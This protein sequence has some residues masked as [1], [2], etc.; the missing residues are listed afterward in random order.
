MRVEQPPHGITT[1]VGQ[2]WRTYECDCG[3]KLSSHDDHV[4]HLRDLAGKADRLTR[5]V[6]NMID[7]YEERAEVYE[8]KALKWW[9]L[10]TQR[11]DEY[12]RLAEVERGRADELRKF[13][14][15]MS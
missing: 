7:I 10:L 5:Y 1:Y 15:G 13:L 9:N 12:E 6:E 14:K 11:A 8:E 3:L 2:G 4:R